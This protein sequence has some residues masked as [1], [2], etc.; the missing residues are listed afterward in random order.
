MQLP[1]PSLLQPSA[2]RT[3]LALTIWREARGESAKCKLAVGY[4]IVQRVKLRRWYG[5]NLSTVLFKKW[6]YSSLTNPKDVQ[7]TTSWQDSLY[8]ASTAMAGEK[9]NPAPG[10]DS[11]FDESIDPPSWA[12]PDDFVLQIGRIKFYDL[13]KDYEAPVV[14]QM[15]AAH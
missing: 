1:Q 9:P 8:A 4:S 10:A 3:F 5:D 13:N 15:G 2:D 7:L 11:Y 14:T 6:Q 12:K